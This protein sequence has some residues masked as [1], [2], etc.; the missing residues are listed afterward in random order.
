M[1]TLLAI[2]FDRNIVLIQ[3][4]RHW[5]LDFKGFP[6]V[7]YMSDSDNRARNGER[8][9]LMQFFSSGS[10]SGSMEP[11]GRFTRSGPVLRFQPV[12]LDRWAGSTGPRFFGPVFRIFPAVPRFRQLS[13]RR[14]HGFAVRFRFGTCRERSGSDFKRFGTGSVPSQ[15][16]PWP[17][18]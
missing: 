6:T 1:S 12:P 16:G 4:L 7:Y 9:K 3:G 13:F 17:S 10:G 11:L 5:K 14:V 8:L 15:P 2:T 18:L